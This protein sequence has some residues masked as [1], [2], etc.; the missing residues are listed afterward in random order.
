[1][2]YSDKQRA[3]ACKLV[4][5]NNGSIDEQTLNDIRM[6]LNAPNLPR[7]TVFRWMQDC[8]SATEKRLQ[9]NY[10]TD[11]LPVLLDGVARSYIRHSET[12][13]AMDR[14]NG[15]QAMTAVGIAIDKMRLMQGLPTEIIQVMPA[16][17]EEI[18]KAGYSAS[19]VFGAMLQ[20]FKTVNEARRAK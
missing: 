11:P 19:D 10:D 15:P 17:I 16:L 5:A 4:E 2:A 6:L 14:T 7:S 3:Q 12:K 13:N 1:M 9:D 20:K 18:G 8:N